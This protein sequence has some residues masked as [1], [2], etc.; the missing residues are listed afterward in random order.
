MKHLLLGLVLVAQSALA[1]D[2]RTEH[3]SQ[4]T[5]Q[6]SVG[7]VTD[8]VKNKSHNKCQVK[9]RISVDG[10]WHN[11]AWTHDGPYQEEIL[12]QM[13]I[14]NG[15]NELLVQLPGKF[16]TESKMVCKP[17]ESMPVTLGYEGKES[18]FGQDPERKMY[19]KIDKISK[20]RMFSGHHA[21]GVSKKL[22]GVICLNNNELWTIVDKF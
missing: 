15:M 18:E 9:F 20:C 16:K 8:L 6:R 2:C 13:A 4:M 7:A 1:Q 10:D 12:C 5:G 19:F 3:T 22:S 14:R 21:D 11:V 17:K